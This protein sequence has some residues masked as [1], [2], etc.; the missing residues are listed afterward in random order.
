MKQ[1]EVAGIPVTVE[2]KRIKNMYLR[3]RPD[4]S[5]HLTAPLHLPDAAITAFAESRAQ[6]L[7]KQRERLARAAP[8]A[9]PAFAEGEPHRLWGRSCPLALL[10]G[11]GPCTAECVDG[12][13][14]LYGGL[15]ATAEQ[16]KKALDDLY[17]RQLLAA[18]PAL[19]R[20]C[21]AVVGRQ[22]AEI[23]LRDMSTRWGSCNVA[24][25]R[26]WL[27]LRLAEY[28][29]DCLRCVLIH[30]L[31]HL[32][33]RRHNA[34]FWGLMDRFCPDWRAIHRLLGGPHGK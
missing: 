10:P 2:K 32:W 22:A 24:K 15:A 14:L 20:Q 6:W 1:I 3:L 4:G 27:S 28:P 12:Q 16:R 13:L 8:P 21:E 9:S 19:R 17:R 18:L 31:T 34:R 25:G 30:E 29:P 33:E 5:A 11:D 26:I 7:L 23:R